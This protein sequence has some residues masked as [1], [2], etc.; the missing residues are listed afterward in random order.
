MKFMQILIVIAIIIGS[1][2]LLHKAVADL[3]MNYFVGGVVGLCSGG[4]VLYWI[5]TEKRG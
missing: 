5:F 1:I 2:A 4:Y 3:D